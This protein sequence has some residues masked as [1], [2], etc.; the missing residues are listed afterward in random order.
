MLRGTQQRGP[1]RLV[2]HDDDT[3]EQRSALGVGLI[4]AVLLAPFAAIGFAW[5]M[6]YAVRAAGVVAL[7]WKA[8]L[9]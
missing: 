2:Q 8:V 5:A 9:S 6:V 1:V 3:Q 4:L 7:V